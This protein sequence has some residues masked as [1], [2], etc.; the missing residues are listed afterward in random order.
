MGVTPDTRTSPCKILVVDHHEDSRVSLSEL[1]RLWGHS[2][3]TAADGGEALLALSRGDFD[4]AL[5]SLNL[6][7][8][9]GFQVARRVRAIKPA[10]VLIALTGWARASYRRR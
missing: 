9:D 6:P 2:V 4:V 10:V 8:L 5:M 1:L 3:E 7:G